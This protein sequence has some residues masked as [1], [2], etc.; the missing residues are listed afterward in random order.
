MDSFVV[1]AGGHAH[2]HGGGA[3]AA[4][5]SSGPSV[6]WV[7]LTSVLSA[8]VVAAALTALVNTVLVRRRSQE[9]ERSRI[10]TTFA[11]ALEAV[12]AYKEFP[13]AIR[14]R[15]A[16]EPANERIRLSEELRH[17]QTRLTYYSTWIHA[18]STKV[19][20]TY[21]DLVTELRIVAGGACREAWRA[22]PITEDSQM[23]IGPDLVDLTSIQPFEAAYASA[24]EKYLTEYVKAWPWS[25]RK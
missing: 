24:A 16:D 21:N 4:A 3:A 12:A 8:S 5:A 11:E 6:G 19:G 10:R 25:K 1:L 18:E 22:D 15:S 2:C 20:T 9:E 7:A 17:V 14:R 23:N 13:Y